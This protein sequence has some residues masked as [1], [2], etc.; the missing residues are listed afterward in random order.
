MKCSNSEQILRYKTPK[1]RSFFSYALNVNLYLKDRRR[2][3]WKTM[4]TILMG[5]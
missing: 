5:I 3:S 4:Q 2:L 1:S